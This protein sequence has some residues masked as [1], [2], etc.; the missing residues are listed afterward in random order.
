MATKIGCETAYEGLT[1]ASIDAVGQSGH[2]SLVKIFPTNDG[3]GLYELDKPRMVIGRMPNC[4][5]EIPDTSISRQHAVIERANG[6]YTLADMSSKNGTYVNDVRIAK[7]RLSPG[8]HVRIGN[9][10]LKYLSPNHIEAQYHEAVY[11]MIT[12]D[13]L[14]GAANK[15]YLLDLLEREISRCERFGRALSVL[16][17]DLDNFKLVN[18]VHGHR[19][20]DEVLKEFSLRVRRV[21]RRDEIFARYG[22]EEFAAML[23]EADRQAAVSAANRVLEAIRISPFPTSAGLISVT[24]SIGVAVSNG[25]QPITPEE[26]LHQADMQ[27]LV[28]K[29]CGKNCVRIQ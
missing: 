5:I 10:I 13:G 4:E 23:Y 26:L 2:G 8:D 21:L 16:L 18:D 11:R 19:A 17:L 14:T 15:D 24:V 29:R 3:P 12:T 27:L 25:M 6:D 7:C 22:G 28:A 20:G 9:H 1:A